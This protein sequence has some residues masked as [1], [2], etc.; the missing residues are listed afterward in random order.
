MLG[1][2]KRGAETQ[3]RKEHLGRAHPQRVVPREPS[4]CWPTTVVNR[5]LCQATR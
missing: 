1:H 4:W 3:L 2:Y 5:H